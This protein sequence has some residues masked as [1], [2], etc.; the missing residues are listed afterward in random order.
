M[1]KRLMREVSKSGRLGCGE[2]RFPSCFH[3]H[4]PRTR[5]LRRHPLEK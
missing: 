5:H 1:Y 4:V 2:T 3:N